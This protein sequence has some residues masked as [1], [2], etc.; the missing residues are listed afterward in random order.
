MVPDPR[1]TTNLNPFASKYPF[2]I[3]SRAVSHAFEKSSAA[4]DTT[5]NGTIENFP[6]FL[7]SLRVCALEANW[8]AAAP[9]GILLHDVDGTARNLLTEHHHMTAAILEA[10]RTAQTNY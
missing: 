1:T 4:L 2:G 6:A 8:G 9:R 5:W 3:G 7:L 10:S